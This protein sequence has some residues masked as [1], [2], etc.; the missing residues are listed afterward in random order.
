MLN[1]LFNF[2]AGSLGSPRPLFY[3][4]NLLLQY[5]LKKYTDQAAI[6]I[7]CISAYNTMLLR[8]I[9]KNHQKQTYLKY[10]E[11]RGPTSN[12]EDN[13]SVVYHTV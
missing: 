10:V 11:P 13:V 1:I 12:F 3:S 9:K 6:Y 4:N 5:F 2:I 7:Y 8:I